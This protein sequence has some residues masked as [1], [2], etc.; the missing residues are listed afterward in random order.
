[1][2]AVPVSLSKP[3]LQNLQCHVFDLGVYEFGFGTK[4]LVVL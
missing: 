2:L 1:M 4:E 3:M